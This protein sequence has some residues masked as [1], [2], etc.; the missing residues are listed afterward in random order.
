MV[1]P[2]ME[3]SSMKV[4]VARCILLPAVLLLLTSCTQFGGPPVQISQGEFTAFF[5]GG[6]VTL[7][8]R[9]IDNGRV[10]GSVDSLMTAPTSFDVPI[11]S[12]KFEVVMKGKGSRYEIS[13]CNAPYLCAN[14]MRGG[15]GTPESVIFHKQS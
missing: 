6:N 5:A 1:P 9:A 3:N 2:P 14:Y 8:V 12:G 7:S 10:R 15:G 4:K 11:T 13:N